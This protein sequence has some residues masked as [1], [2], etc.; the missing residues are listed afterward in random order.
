MK[1]QIRKLVVSSFLVCSL[2]MQGLPVLAEDRTYNDKN[3][4]TNTGVDLSTPDGLHIAQPKEAITTTADK[5]YITGTSDPNQTLTI[6]GNPVED[7][8]RFGTFG[9]LVT[10]E[11]GKN[12]FT[13]KNGAQSAT[14]TITRQQAPTGAATTKTLT[15]AYPTFN[16]IVYAG[17]YT[18]TC[19]APAGAS[20]TASVAGKTV[21]L[22]QTVAAAQTGVPANFKGTV[23]LKDP[24]G[25]MDELGKVTYTMTYQGNT[26]T[27]SSAGTVTVLH[28]DATPTVELNRHAVSVYEEGNKN[29][30]FV[31]TLN[32]GA[33]D[34]LV[35]M[36]ETMAKL[37]MNG[38]VMK[39]C[40]S[41]VEGNPSIKNKVSACT[42]DVSAGGEYLTIKGTASST[43]KAY[44]DSEKVYIKFYN[45]SG[46]GEVS[47]SDSALFSR[48]SVAAEDGATIFKFM[49]K[50]ANNLIGYDINYDGEGDITVFFN[51]MP[52]LDSNAKPLT[53]VTV[54]ID[55]GH[56]GFDPGALG[57][58]GQDGPNEKDI[59]MAH[60]IATVNR[61]ESLG[62]N[63]IMTV[64]TDLPKDK[65][66]VLDERIDLTRSEE[67][68]F[69][70]SLHC[71]S[72]AGTKND[73]K[74]KG[75]EVYYY[76]SF[77]KPFAQTMLNKLSAYTSRYPRGS[78]YSTYYVT[79]MTVCP[80]ILVEMGFMTN[81][82]EYDEMRSRDS[83]FKTANAVANTILTYLEA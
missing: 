19:V 43:F 29:S 42:Y 14:V 9:A 15:K 58:L 40:L 74:A 51:P 16:D 47:A 17:E 57:V 26:K 59:T 33:Q 60:A 52:T 66:F 55:P 54:A 18:L 76:E 31:S 5:Y 82:I 36:N 69:F 68:D 67:A 28:K 2:L 24:S 30:S 20:V 73:L 56:G 37:S 32:Q 3:D 25:E 44:M 70:V 13:V 46:A 80:S 83:M 21:T 34:K 10:L 79:K 71:N 65:K 6:D 62:A 35:D 1:K 77:S 4:I 22:N 61:L 49:K 12:T 23:M 27:F 75:S 38:W 45:M 64:P 78:F 53:G 8:G 11:M 63:V 50:S 81:P 72:V 48:V 41:L 7:V 39:E